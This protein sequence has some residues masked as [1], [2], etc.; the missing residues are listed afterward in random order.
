MFLQAWFWTIL[1]ETIFLLLLVKII[2]KKW[3]PKAQVFDIIFTGIISSSLTIPYLWFIY[4]VYFSGN[5]FVGEILVVLVESLVIAKLL[6]L[7]I[8]R[9]LLVSFV[10]NL[11]SFL[12]GL[13]IF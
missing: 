11:I 2:F 3:L 5:L 10:C 13:L 8:K 12:F 6:N 4:P 7:N 1:I 9:S